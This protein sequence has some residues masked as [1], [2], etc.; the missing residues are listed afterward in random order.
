M[1]LTNQDNHEGLFVLHHLHDVA[2]QF[3]HKLTRF[4]KPPRKQGMRID[5]KQSRMRVPEMI[6]EHHT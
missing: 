3:L 2:E 4:R 6:N 5:L 1:V